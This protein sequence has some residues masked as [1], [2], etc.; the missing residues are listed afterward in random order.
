MNPFQQTKLFEEKIKEKYFNLKALTQTFNKYHQNLFITQGKLGNC[1][2]IA[3][4][5]QILTKADFIF[6]K[7]WIFESY[8]RDSAFV[9]LNIDGKP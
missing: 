1:Y 3:A 5:D 9:I 7:L 6:D 4:F 8:L 2:M